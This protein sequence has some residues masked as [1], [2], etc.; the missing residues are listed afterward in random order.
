MRQKIGIVAILAL[1]ILV[2]IACSG[3]PLP[4]I[5]P[6]QATSAPSATIASA[7]APINLTFWN[8]WDGKNGEVIQSLVDKYNQ[9]HPNV[10]V[11]NVFIGYGDLLTKLQAGVAG[12]ELPNVAAGDMAWVSKFVQSKSLVPLNDYIQKSNVPLADFYPELLKIDRAGNDIVA[13]PVSTNNLELFYNQDLF[14][15]AGLDPNTPPKTWDELISFAQKCGKPDG[16]VAG[17]ELYTEPGEGLTWQWQVYLWQ[18]GGEF[19]VDNKP[20]FNSDAGRKAL[21]F[22]VDLIQKYKV[23]PLTKWG[24]FEKGAACMRIDGSWV[25]SDLAQKAPFKWNT[26]RVPIPTGGKPATNM[27]GEHI[28]IFKSDPAHEAAAWDFLNYLTSTE[29]QIEWDQQTSFMPIR[30]SVA[31]NSGFLDYVKNKEPRLIPFVEN[32]KYAHARPGIVQYAEISDAFS[33]EAE[34]AL[35]GTQSVADAL[36]NAE[37]AAQN[38]LAQ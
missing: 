6:S 15:A 31:T 32:Q 24:L 8:Y 20:A 11:K 34:K 4:T 12:G 14:Q 35:H 16:S 26:A 29:T 25:I 21:Q 28:F 3:T 13:L 23:S 36:N 2:A 9:S 30:D 33:K 10:Q 37:K 19:M 5:A 7:A 27:G 18:A 17:M 22:F 1:V 38:I